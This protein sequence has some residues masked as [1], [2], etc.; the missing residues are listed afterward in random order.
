MQPTGI[1][2]DPIVTHIALS[3]SPNQTFASLGGPLI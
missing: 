3:F 1:A 2:S